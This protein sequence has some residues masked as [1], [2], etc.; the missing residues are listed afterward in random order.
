MPNTPFLLTR[1][2]RML[3]A[4]LSVAVVSGCATY[5]N[6]TQQ[7][8]QYVLN[9]DSAKL[10]GDDNLNGFLSQ[11]PAG[12]VMNLVYSPWGDNVEIIADAPYLAASGR[13]CRRLRVVESGSGAAGTALT[14]ETPNGWVN[15][16]VLSPSISATSTAAQGRY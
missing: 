8:A 5:P 13:E 14:C 16:R 15:Q 4:A 1:P 7:Q 10:L 9:T 2:A 3:L 12:A 11:A 6:S